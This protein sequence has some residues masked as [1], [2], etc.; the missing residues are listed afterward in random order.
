MIQFSVMNRYD[1]FDFSGHAHDHFEAVDGL[2]GVIRQGDQH[3]ATALHISRIH[4]MT[5][6]LD[7]KFDMSLMYRRRDEIPGF[8]GIL[9]GV[10][11]FFDDVG[12]RL[13][14]AAQGLF[15]VVQG[16]KETVANHVS[17]ASLGLDY[18]G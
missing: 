13:A 17:L 11:A 9:P 2:Q 16:R 6:A 4:L 15:D 10:V 12:V 3:T 14:S 8:S 1:F 7:W 18:G 5:A